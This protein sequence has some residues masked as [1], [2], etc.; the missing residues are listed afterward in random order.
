MIP[1]G[2]SD[3]CFYKVSL[4]QSLKLTRSK[5]SN[6]NA[7]KNKTGVS[8][9]KKIIVTAKISVIRCN[10]PKYVRVITEKNIN[11]KNDFK[12]LER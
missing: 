6:S 3:S 10:K 11:F 12:K 2:D 4:F 1:W 9:V 8:I 7:K 5:N